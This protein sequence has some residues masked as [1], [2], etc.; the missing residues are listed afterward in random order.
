MYAYIH[1]YIHVHMHTY[2]CIQGVQARFQKAYSK[3]KTTCAYAQ[4]DTCMNT[5]THTHIHACREC[6]QEFKKHIPKT[7]RGRWNAT[8]DME[9]VRQSFNA[10]IHE[11]RYVCMYVC[12]ACMSIRMC[13]YVCVCAC[14]YLCVCLEKWTLECHS[15]YGGRVAVF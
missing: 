2:T 3:D 14:V 12:N 15:R 1:T 5:Y 6:E 10:S 8:Q 9:D 13:V 7:K 4:M 11:R